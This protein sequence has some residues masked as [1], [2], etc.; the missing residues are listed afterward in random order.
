MAGGFVPSGL[1]REL[2]LTSALIGA[3]I[4]P[5]AGY[6]MPDSSF[7]GHPWL[8]EPLVRAIVYC[9]FMAGVF[10]VAIGIGIPWTYT[11]I[12]GRSADELVTVTGWRNGSPRV[13]EGPYL[14]E[15]PFIP[16][17]CLDESWKSKLPDGT[18]LGVSGKTSPMGLDASQVHLP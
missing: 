18:K 17:I 14:A 13:C 15:A 8:Q 11:E 16:S 7:A 2:G 4:G 5:V 9:P 6:F 1:G 12:F 3:V 10:Y